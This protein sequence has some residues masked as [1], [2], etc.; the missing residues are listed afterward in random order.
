MRVHQTIDRLI[1]KEL[2]SAGRN[3][4]PAKVLMLGICLL[5]LTKAGSVWAQADHPTRIFYDT[6]A[7]NIHTTEMSPQGG[8]K[9][10]ISHRF[11]RLNSGAYELFGLDQATI[12]IGLD[13]GVFDWLN[14]GVGRSSLGKTYD[15][16]VKANVFE[17]QEGKSPVALSGL[18][19]GSVNGLRWA[20]P[21]RENYFSSRITYHFQAMV[22]RRFHDRFSLMLSPGI[23]HRNLVATRDEAHDIWSL[24]STARFLVTKRITLIGQYL[25][26]GPNQLPDGRTNALALG[27]DVETK[28]HVFQLYFGNARGMTEVLA[29]TETTGEVLNGDIHFGFNI[30]R[31]FQVGGKKH[32]G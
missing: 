5:L 10:I 27:I 11:G 8:A 25:F 2:F 16:F 23:T 3:A 32:K 22:A 28:G 29:I 31:D 18:A 13:Y 19:M 7:L 4:F 26:V 20:D 21:S 14:V 30:T 24:G 9:F 17:Q 15:G 1:K 6:R 12:R